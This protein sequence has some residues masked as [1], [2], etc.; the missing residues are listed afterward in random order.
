L[1]HLTFHPAAYF[2]LMASFFAET[3]QQYFTCELPLP[4][5]EVGGLTVGPSFPPPLP[6]AVRRLLLLLML[7]LLL[8]LVGGS[9]AAAHHSRHRCFVLLHQ[10]VAKNDRKRY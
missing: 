7:L 2:F 1:Q 6:T 9:G 4:L 3:W 5:V 10:N 8:L